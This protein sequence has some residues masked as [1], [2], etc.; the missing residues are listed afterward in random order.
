VGR[1]ANR[2]KNAQFKLEGKT[3]KLEANNGSHHLHGL[4]R[5]ERV[6]VLDELA[7]HASPPPGSNPPS[8]WSSTRASA[9]SSRPAGDG[10]CV[11]VR[12]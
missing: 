10:G 6:G 5:R 11:C 12:C 3:Y 7:P 8:S 4:Q 1:V 2:I 9:A